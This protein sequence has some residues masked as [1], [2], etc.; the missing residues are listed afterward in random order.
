MRLVIGIIICL[1]LLQASAA[2][3][4]QQNCHSRYTYSLDQGD[5]AV[6]VAHHG[7]VTFSWVLPNR[8][9]DPEGMF[10]ARVSEEYGYFECQPEVNLRPLSRGENGMSCLKLEVKWEPGT[11]SSGCFVEILKN[12]KPVRRVELFMIY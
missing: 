8:N 12:G 3:A 4:N 11:D 1:F 10:S 9:V 6:D 7:P 2:W 5:R